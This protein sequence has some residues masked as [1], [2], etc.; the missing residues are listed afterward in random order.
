MLEKI[1]ADKI[2]E[3]LGSTGDGFRSGEICDLGL[4]FDGFDFTVFIESRLVSW[5][6]ETS[7]EDWEV[8]WSL[9]FIKFWD[10][11][12][13]AIEVDYDETNINHYLNN[14]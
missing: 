5:E 8:T 1:I 9:H 13:D 6:T 2:R 14:Y 11:E 3:R 12:G 10:S 7:P 4:T